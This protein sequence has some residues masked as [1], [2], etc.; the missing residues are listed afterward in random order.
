MATIQYTKTQ[1][2]HMNRCTVDSR[3]DRLAGCRLG[4]DVSMT[5]QQLARAIM[6]ASR[7]LQD[8]ANSRDSLLEPEVLEAAQALDDFIVEYGQRRAL[9][10]AQRR[11]PS[12]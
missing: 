3:L 1:K 6:N 5:L 12:A 9:K 7:T 4:V 2:E 11:S 8:I 10:E